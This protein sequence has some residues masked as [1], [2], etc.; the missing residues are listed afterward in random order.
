MAAGRGDRA[1]VLLRGVVVKQLKRKCQ[2]CGKEVSGE[3]LY[4][5]GGFPVIHRCEKKE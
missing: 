3:V 1:R 2:A 4:Y 5:V